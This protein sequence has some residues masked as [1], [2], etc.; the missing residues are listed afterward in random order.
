MN[1][2]DESNVLLLGKHRHYHREDLH[3]VDL[4]ISHGK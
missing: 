4:H 3:H 1:V 2:C